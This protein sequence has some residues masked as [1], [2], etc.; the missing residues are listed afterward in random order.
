MRRTIYIAQL[1]LLNSFIQAHF[2]HFHERIDTEHF[3]LFHRSPVL[4]HM[5]IL[6]A[7]AMHVPDTELP[8]LGD[9][10]TPKFLN[11][12]AANPGRK[13]LAPALPALPVMIT[14]PDLLHDVITIPAIE[15]NAAPT[16][17]LLLAR[18]PPV[19]L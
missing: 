11:W 16:V 13:W 12:L 2:H 17:S 8:I 10:N 7:R 15:A 19:C 4:L 14:L 3:R 9:S 5:H 1:L 18:A 6:P